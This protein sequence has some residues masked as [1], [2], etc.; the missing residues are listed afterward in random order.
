MTDENEKRVADALKVL[1][2]HFDAVQIFVLLKEENVCEVNARGCGDIY[3]RM[4]YAREWLLVQEER[5]RMDVRRQIR[6]E[7]ADGG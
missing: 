7:E 1:G 2:E 6:E 5:A 3:A 4:G